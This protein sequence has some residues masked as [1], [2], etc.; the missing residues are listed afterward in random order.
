MKDCTSHRDT[1]MSITA[2]VQRYRDGEVPFILEAPHSRLIM[3]RFL[4]VVLT[5]ILLQGCGVT[6]RLTKVDAPEPITGKHEI[7]PSNLVQ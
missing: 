4:L 5:V 7:V 6:Y 1:W 2:T 3:I